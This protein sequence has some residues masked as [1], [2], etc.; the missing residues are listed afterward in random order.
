MSDPRLPPIPQVAKSG[1]NGQ[2]AAWISSLFK[3][4]NELFRSIN[5]PSGWKIIHPINMGGSAPT[6]S[7][8]ATQYAYC[9]RLQTASQQSI[10]LT[11]TL[12]TDMAFTVPDEEGN[13]QP[14]KLYLR[15]EWFSKGTSTVA[16]RSAGEYNYIREGELATGNFAYL[17]TK[18]ITPSGVANEI[19]SFEHNVLVNEKFEPGGTVHLFYVRKGDQDTNPDDIY[20][21]SITLRYY[22]DG[23][24]TNE[25]SPSSTDPRYT[26]RP[27]FAP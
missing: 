22:S 17:N 25:R 4:L 27:T 11:F 24:A 1:L 13:Q 18:D 20:I 12:P 8:A 16:W 14:P 3:R 26:K 15:I 2:F 6:G 9:W 21:T 7:I 23:L 19:Q 10:C 5:P